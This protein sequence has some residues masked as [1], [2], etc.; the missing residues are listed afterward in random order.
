[1]HWLH[2]CI[3]ILLHSRPTL[4][5]FIIFR[6]TTCCYNS[7]QTVEEYYHDLDK[8]SNTFQAI[9]SPY[10]H[11]QSHST[12]ITIY[13]FH[14]LHNVLQ[15]ISHLR[16]PCKVSESHPQALPLRGSLLSQS[17]CGHQ[18]SVQLHPICN[19]H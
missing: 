14:F 11:S 1:M 3:S 16:R 13:L 4:Q 5:L 2:F 9:P 18:R 10:K 7:V 15:H 17:V 6:L 12:S 19:P 8:Q